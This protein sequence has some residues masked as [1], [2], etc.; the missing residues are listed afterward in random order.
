MGRRLVRRGVTSETGL[1]RGRG[2]RRGGG[3]AEARTERARR[4]GRTGSSIVCE[5]GSS[6]E[7]RTMPNALAAA[8]SSGRHT[9]RHIRVAYRRARAWSRARSTRGDKRT[10]HAAQPPMPR[11]RLARGAPP[12]E[13][14][15][16][17]ARRLEQCREPTATSARK[18]ARARAASS[19]NHDDLPLSSSSAS[20]LPRRERVRS[21][22][23][24]SGDARADDAS[25]RR[26]QPHRFRSAKRA[27]PHP[28]F[29]D[30]HAPRVFTASHHRGPSRSPSR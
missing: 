30:H 5:F 14:G 13:D 3:G 19:R 11:A 16:M 6:S 27:R 17:L 15:A 23:P 22:R 8:R 26:S 1:S 18:S 12:E 28:S 21:A 4:A 10:P 24:G 29:T 9:E 7:G 20:D 2:R 25:R